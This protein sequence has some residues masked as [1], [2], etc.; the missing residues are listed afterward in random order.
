MNMLKRFGLACLLVSGFVACDESSET[1]VDVV[2]SDDGTVVSHKGLVVADDG[3]GFIVE[4]TAPGGVATGDVLDLL[5]GIQIAVVA[6]EVAPVDEGSTPI[7]DGFAPAAA[8]DV[9][10]LDR[11]PNF[12]VFVHQDGS[13][14]V[15][16]NRWYVIDIDLDAIAEFEDSCPPWH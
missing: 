12:D 11:F 14:I 4:I 5:D 16:D 3:R 7:F 8:D 1:S 13:A 10:I 9:Y 15:E 2:T 6:D